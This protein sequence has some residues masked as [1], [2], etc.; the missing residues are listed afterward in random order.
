VT[1]STIAEKY[2]YVMI[3][4][5]AN[6]EYVFERG[7]KNLFS[8]LPPA[9]EALKP[10]PELALK[11]D[12]SLKTYAAVVLD[13]AFT[14]PLGDGVRERSKELGLTELYYGKYPGGTTDFSLILT[15][16]KDKKPDIIYFGGFFNECVNFYRQAKQYD[17]N[18]K[19]WGI[20]AGP[21]QPDWL[22]VMGADGDFVVT[23]QFYSS[24][25]DYKGTLFAD[26]KAFNEY[27][28]QKY[29]RECDHFTSCGFVSGVLLKLAIE[30]ADSLDQMAI[31]EALAKNTFNTFLGP[32]KFDEKGRNLGRQEGLLQVQKGQHVLVWPEVAGGGRMIYPT[33][34]WKDR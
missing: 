13:N 21:S 22:K 8:V 1:T 34:A 16:V 14:L 17:L 29:G 6:G 32:F 12:P 5:M 18:A 11:K 27:W 28:Q 7:L 33:P 9:S 4:P 3:T 23:N 30:K 20:S 19:V 15:A 25:L 24:K 26:T 2:G 31:R 10:V